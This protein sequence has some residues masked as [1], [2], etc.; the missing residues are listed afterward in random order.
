[1]I[2]PCENFANSAGHQQ[3]LLG[4]HGTQADFRREDLS[5]FLTSMSSQTCRQ[6]RHT[7]SA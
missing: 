3:T 7:G 5:V 6:G 2:L 4:F 1:M